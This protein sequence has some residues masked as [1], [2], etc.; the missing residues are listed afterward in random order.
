MMLAVGL[1]YYRLYYVSAVTVL[2]LG[3]EHSSGDS[4][5]LHQM[6]SVLVR[7]VGILRSKGCKGSEAYQGSPALL[8]PCGVKSL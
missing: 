6:V 3:R 1:S 5:Q 4:G 8:F 2:A 7:T